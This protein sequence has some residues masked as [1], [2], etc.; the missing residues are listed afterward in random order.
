MH[1]YTLPPLWHTRS[2][3]GGALSCLVVS[4][5]MVLIH[6]LW[7]CALTQRHRPAAGFSNYVRKGSD[8]V[9]LRLLYTVL[10]CALLC[11]VLCVCTG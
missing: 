9:L 10:Y 8:T 1:I 6:S 4:L 5:T 7:I 3:V 2:S 11:M